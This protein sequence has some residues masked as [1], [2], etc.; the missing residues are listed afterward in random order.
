[1][2][3]TEL[4]QKVTSLE[5][6]L[7][8]LEQRLKASEQENFLLRQKLDALARRYFGKKSEQLNSAQME[9]LLAGLD[10]VEVDLPATPKAPTK[11][12]RRERNGAQRVRTPE[13]LEVVQRVIEPK[14][15][16]AQ[17]QQWE[18]ISQEVSRQLDYQPGKFFWL[19]TVRPKYV[20]TDDRQ[21]A[22]IPI[23]SFLRSQF[24]S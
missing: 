1:M 20:R 19:E 24:G 13:N 9:L 5:A 10:E 7:E 3:A 23:K 18:K 11:S 2:N 14:E 4:Q 12:V 8:Q 15:V 22:K 16:Q 17:P 21:A 6:K